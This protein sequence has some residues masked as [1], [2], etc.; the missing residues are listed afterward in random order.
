MSKIAIASI[1][2]LTILPIGFFIFTYDGGRQADVVQVPE[3]PDKKI[4]IPVAGTTGTTS[5]QCAVCAQITDT[6]SKEQCFSDFS[7]G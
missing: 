7:C 3:L 4:N 6:T 5:S 2:F 1:L